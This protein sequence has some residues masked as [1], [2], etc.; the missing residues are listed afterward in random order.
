M[1]DSVTV[2][3]QSESASSG[4][5]A[6]AG[7]MDLAGGMNLAD[8]SGMSLAGRMSLAGGMKLADDTGLNLA[9]GVDL[10][11]EGGM[12]LAGGMNLETVHPNKKKDLHCCTSPKSARFLFK[13]MAATSS[14]CLPLDCVVSSRV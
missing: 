10:A 5:E 3:D 1:V 8:E 2:S 4:V 13:F 6:V 12:N 9:G 14:S 11:D 7:G